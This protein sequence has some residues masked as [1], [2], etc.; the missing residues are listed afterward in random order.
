VI[1]DTAV[2]RGVRRNPLMIGANVLVGPRAS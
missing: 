1:M 2:L